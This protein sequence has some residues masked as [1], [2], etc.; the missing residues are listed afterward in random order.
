MG[1]QIKQTPQVA[2]SKQ[3][4]VP[5]GG[6]NYIPNG[7]LI[8]IILKALREAQDNDVNRQQMQAEAEQHYY[9]ALGNI[10]GDPTK[11]IIAIAAQNTV[12]AGVESAKGL[13]AMGKSLAISAGI[14]GATAVGTL[15][16][17]AYESY[18]ADGVQGEIT[19]IKADQAQLDNLPEGDIEVAKNQRSEAQEDTDLAS[20]LDNFAKGET[21]DQD[22]MEAGKLDPE[23]VQKRRKVQD[24]QIKEKERMRDEHNTKSRRYTEMGQTLINVVSSSTQAAGNI[25]KAPHDAAAAANNAAAEVSKNLQQMDSSAA[26]NFRDSAHAAAQQALATADTL[27]QVAASQVQM[28]G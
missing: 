1:T 15:G 8:A 21:V 18:K 2:V 3:Q 25:Q 5:S 27:A 12:N 23:L 7:L 28:R 17:G 6:Q 24:D 19:T 11:G 26:N 16:G 22:T 9:K 4:N 13:E 14:S 10:G 20:R